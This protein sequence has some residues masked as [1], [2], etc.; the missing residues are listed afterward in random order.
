MM[1]QPQSALQNLPYDVAASIIDFLPLQEQICLALTCHRLQDL[2]EAYNKKPLK[3]IA[4][5]N[6]WCSCEGH[7]WAYPFI[8]PH[9]E[10]GFFDLMEVLK[11]WMPPGLKFCHFC[12]KYTN[13]KVCRLAWAFNAWCSEWNVCRSEAE[14]NA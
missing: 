4:L 5:D 12:L 3:Q 9:P 2:V 6:L 11:A 8:T 10:F 14:V 1:A 13:H 7:A